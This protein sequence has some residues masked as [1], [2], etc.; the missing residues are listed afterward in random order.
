MGS[1]FF[2][3]ARASFGG[4][5][6]YPIVLKRMI[7]FLTDSICPGQFVCNIIKG[8]FRKIFPKGAYEDLIALTCCDLVFLL[9][10]RP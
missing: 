1:G 4:V 5:W 3:A 8:F 10:M 2:F 6:W 9:E 7:N